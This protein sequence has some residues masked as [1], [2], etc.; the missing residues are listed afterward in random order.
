M[1]VF[2][3]CTVSVPF[4][5]LR[6]PW[7]LR[8]GGNLY[9]TLTIRV[10]KIKLTHCTLM[11]LPIDSYRSFKWYNESY[12]PYGCDGTTDHIFTNQKDQLRGDDKSNLLH[13]N[14]SLFQMEGKERGLHRPT[15]AEVSIVLKMAEDLWAVKIISVWHTFRC[16]NSSLT[17]GSSGDHCQPCMGWLMVGISIAT[18]R[19]ACALK[20]HTCILMTKYLIHIT[21]NLI[22]IVLGYS[23]CVTDHQLKKYKQ[24]SPVEGQPFHYK[25]KSTLALKV[26]N[27]NNL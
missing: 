10:Y 14:G 13:L 26:H 21:M 2:T 27:F 1:K 19:T 23:H 12:L 20:L 11:T 7:L 22:H 15:F 4:V 3:L 5:L 17:C 9:K 24:I 6:L 25:K 16:S 18:S 8:M